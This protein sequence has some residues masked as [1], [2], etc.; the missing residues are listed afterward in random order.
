[1]NAAAA[2]A[3]MRLWN[4]GFASP[5]TYK[6]YD[7][8]DPM[9]DAIKYLVKDSRLAAAVFFTYS[10]DMRAFKARFSAAEE[11]ITLIVHGDKCVSDRLHNSGIGTYGNQGE[12]AI[13]RVVQSTCAAREREKE[14]LM[15]QRMTKTRTLSRVRAASMRVNGNVTIFQSG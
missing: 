10:F 1:M 13:E 8:S 14:M 11:S 7:E 3:R 2:A 5:Q 9:S 15:N 4:D 6:T 12:W